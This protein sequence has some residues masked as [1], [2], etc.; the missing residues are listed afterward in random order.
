MGV[1]A[2]TTGLVSVRGTVSLASVL[3]LYLLVVVVVA[4]I[5]GLA[6][7]LAAAIASFA[8]ANWFLTPPYGT[9]Q[10]QDGDS[11]I[12]LVVFVAV[13]MIVAVT[14]DLAARDRVTAARSRLEAHLLSRFAAEP[15][16]ETG[17][18]QILE[19]VRSLFGF[20]SVA[21]TD[22]RGGR[23]RVLASVGPP[24][25]AAPSI[26]IEP[27]DGLALN[28]HGPALFAEDRGL[29]MR[30][31]TSAARAWE[32][33][34]LSEQARQAS[35][36]AAADKLRSALL[37]AVGH[38]LRTPLAG[39][40]AAVG[41][42]RQDDIDLVAG[43]RAELLLSIETAADR[44]DDLVSNLLAMSR[45]QAG[46]LTVHRQ[47]VVLQ[48]VVARAVLDLSQP[49]VRIDVADNLPLVDAD[50]GL[51]ERVVANLINNAVRFSPSGRSVQVRAVPDPPSRVALQVIDSGPGV[52]GES[53]ERMFIPF[54]RLG[55]QPD[56]GGV[57]LGLA[58]AR[59]FTEAMGGTLVPSHTQGGG[60]TMTLTLRTTS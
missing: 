25:S 22:I 33:Q 39:I 8:L 5:G 26:V 47:P 31:A 44:L 41:T 9:F 27:E 24:T 38:D 4:A 60:L 14:V 2:L 37:A 16:T 21:L 59:G 45:L 52:A 49:D 54:Q 23:L 58:I 51:L 34:Q 1:P 12:A 30:L 15:L 43:D 42:L 48:E 56:G 11:V 36:L 18:D 20:T 17:V 13:S 57:G 19:Q 46:G 28:G 7:A 3:L 32:G 35:H 53:W 29:L 40:K 10:V 55:D 50:P 6:P